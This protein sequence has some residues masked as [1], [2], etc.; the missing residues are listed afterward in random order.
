MVLN[1]S[2]PR[3]AE[4][5]DAV[6]ASLEADGVDIVDV[7]KVERAVED[8]SAD[9]QS[10]D[11]R[12]QIAESQGIR[13]FV[14]GRVEPAGRRRFRVR[15][16]VF[17]GDDGSMVG[18]AAI[19]MR[20]RG[21]TRRLEAA[22]AQELRGGLSKA[23]KPSG[24]SSGSSGG[25][26][27]AGYEFAIDEVED[28]TDEVEEEEPPP[29]PQRPR[30]PRR[31]EPEVAQTDEVDDDEEVPQ[32]AESDDEE[33]EEVEDTDTDASS[34]R[35]PL[36]FSGGMSFIGRSLAFKDKVG[37]LS[38]HKIQPNPAL[39]IGGEFYPLGLVDDNW[40]SHIGLEFRYAFLL[41]ASSRKGDLEYDTTAHDLL[42][43]LRGRL[44]L[45][46][47]DLG[48]GIGYGSQSM[49]FEPAEDGSSAEVPEYGYSFVRFAANGRFVF[50]DL[51]IEPHFALLLPLG[52]GEVARNEWFPHM[53]GTGIDAGA[54]AGWALGGHVEL[55]AGFTY[56]QWGLTFNP[57]PTDLRVSRYGGAAGGATDRY[58]YIDVGAAYRF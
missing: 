33:D 43:G 17:S 1:F 54:R 42:I 16:G 4:A 20:R 39:L 37:S 13:A 50:G 58:V 10:A 15:M 31:R 21:L 53:S 25:G 11:G 5:R 6:E 24:G 49:A 3:G 35:S 22:A 40:A 8:M 28:V 47:H 48:L 23:R 2:G 12:K 52:F 30:R 56:R 26:G 55:F 7:G 32:S 29:R 38:D 46:A 57:E 14:A 9:L 41:F 19:G 36:V 27:G 34:A 44:P 18:T 51:S 45:G